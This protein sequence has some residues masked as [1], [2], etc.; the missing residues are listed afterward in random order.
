MIYA[1]FTIIQPILQLSISSVDRGLQAILFVFGR[2][3]TP[4]EL[5]KVEPNI[6]G[7]C[8][9]SSVIACDSSKMLAGPAL[10]YGRMQL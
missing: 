9:S 8:K 2:L 4:R 3:H 10:I 6:R 7:I 5:D 1:F